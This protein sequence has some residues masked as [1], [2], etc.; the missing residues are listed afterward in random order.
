ML[1]TNTT[2]EHRRALE[3]LTRRGCMRMLRSTV[4]YVALH[5]S[6]NYPDLCHDAGGAFHQ[7]PGS[8]SP[9]PL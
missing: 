2:G 3:T 5:R 7:R 1:A 6:A 4:G 9:Q 8:K